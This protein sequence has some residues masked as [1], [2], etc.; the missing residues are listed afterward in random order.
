MKILFFFMLLLSS[1]LSA[2]HDIQAL[3]KKQAQH[4]NNPLINYNLGVAQYKQSVYQSAAEN[5]QRAYQHAEGNHTIAKQALFNA[6]KSHEQYGLH[7]LPDNWQQPE[8]PVDPLVLDKAT[9][10]LQEAITWY[11]KAA[12]DEKTTKNRTLAE[13][14]LE[15]LTKKKQEQK[16]N[17]EKNEKEK[18]KNLTVNI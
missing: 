11:A 15:E 12:Q 9:K 1:S 18:R 16:R 6:A 3:L 7:L 17:Q 2:N 8:V 5:F 13:K 14:I 4:P 10:A